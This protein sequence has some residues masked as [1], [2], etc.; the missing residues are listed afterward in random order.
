MFNFLIAIII[1]TEFYTLF[2]DNGICDLELKKGKIDWFGSVSLL[3][4]L[5]NCEIIKI[6]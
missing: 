3:V 2:V 5:K 6:K 1:D 4:N